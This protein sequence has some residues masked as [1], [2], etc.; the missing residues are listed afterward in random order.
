MYPWPAICLANRATGPVTVDSGLVGPNLGGQYRGSECRDRTLI[1]FAEEH[2]PGKTS[3][4][5]KSDDGYVA[6]II[7]VP[8]AFGY[9]GMVG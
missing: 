9:P 3:G 6:N 8:H 7:L 5:N 2:N 1:D 4:E